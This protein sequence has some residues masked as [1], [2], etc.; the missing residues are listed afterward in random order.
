MVVTGVRSVP[1][2]RPR[3][4]Y[5]DD[6][7]LPQFVSQLVSKNWL[8]ASTHPNT[9]A[10]EGRRQCNVQMG[11]SKPRL[12]VIGFHSHSYPRSKTQTAAP[13]SQV[14]YRSS[15]ARAGRRP[16]LK[17]LG[18]K[19]RP[20]ELGERRLRICAAPDLAHSLSRKIRFSAV[21]TGPHRDAFY[22]KKCGTA[23]KAARDFA[24]L[25]SFA[26]AGGAF[27]T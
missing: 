15:D 24:A 12:A 7:P 4:W 8:R 19:T 10:W 27:I 25:K 21:W 14:I 6:L 18:C 5:D 26:T 9:A 1:R 2:D 23:S 3:F 11:A 17:H 16:P 13:Q 22:Y 20:L